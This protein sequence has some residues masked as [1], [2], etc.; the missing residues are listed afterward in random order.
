MEH[1]ASSIFDLLINTGSKF[2]GIAENLKS[3]DA[4]TVS[5]WVI[6]ALNLIYLAKGPP[7]TNVKDIS[8][9]SGFKTLGASDGACLV[10]A[11]VVQWMVRFLCKKLMQL[12][13]PE[14]AI[15]NRKYFILL[16]DI[17]MCINV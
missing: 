11:V 5:L 1:D 7:N 14:S 13:T 12:V 15:L 4:T 17:C 3:H 2:N 8:E 6:E 16:I 10:T 9:Q